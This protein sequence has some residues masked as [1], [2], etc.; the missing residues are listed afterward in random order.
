MRNPVGDIKLLLE[1][2][3][4]DNEHL[5]ETAWRCQLLPPAQLIRDRT[6]NHYFMVVDVVRS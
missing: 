6:T 3:Q 4:R 2:H 1:L 5:A